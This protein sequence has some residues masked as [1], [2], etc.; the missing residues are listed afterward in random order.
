MKLSRRART[1]LIAIS[2]P[3]LFVIAFTIVILSYYHFHTPPSVDVTTMSFAP[4]TIEIPEGEAIHFVNQSSTTTQIIC[5]GSNKQ[6]QTTVVLSALQSPPPQ[7]LLNV[8]LSVEVAS[9]ARLRNRTCRFCVIRLLNDMVLVM[10]T[11]LSMLCMP[12]IVTVPMDRTLVA[13]VVP[14]ACAFGNNMID[15]NVVLIFEKEFTPT[16]F[17]LLLLKQSTQRST[18]HWVF[19]ES[20]A[21][22]EEI[23][24]I[25]TRRSSHFDVALNR[26]GVV[27]PERV[28]F[29]VLENPA[30]SWLHL[31]VFVNDPLPSLGGMPSVS[32]SP[33]LLIRQM[34][35]EGEW[36]CCYH[37]SVVVGPSSNDRIQGS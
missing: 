26:S 29:L 28:L 19:F 9:P 31:P 5:V 14:S 8:T 20:C 1:W 37:G 13:E 30:C 11:C 21:P 6:C 34:I 33:Q 22:V 25:W 4:Q 24:V 10:N 3:L 12:L 27:P 15:L 2:A 16:A 35:T 36:F 7:A 23:A 18:Q 17:P 32:P